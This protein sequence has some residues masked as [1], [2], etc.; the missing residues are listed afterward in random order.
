[1]TTAQDSLRPGAVLAG[2]YEVLRL[3]GIGARKQVHVAHD[4][5]LDRDVAVCA[6][7]G[8]PEEAVRLRR[9]AALLARLGDHPCIVA[10]HDLLEIG[11]V[12]VMICQY[13]PGGALNEAL[14]HRALEVPAALRIASDV[15]AAL[16][17]AHHHDV[18]HRDVKPANI[19]LDGQGRAV[20]GDF[21]IA[22]SGSVDVQ[23][24]D[25]LAGTA[26]YAAP[27][28][29]VGDR[30]DARSDLYSLGSVLFELLT[31]RPPFADPSLMGVV[32][33]VLQE[34]AVPPSS[35][36]PELPEG[37]D[38]L[39][40][41][42][43]AKDPDQRPSSADELL[44][45]LQA[46][47]SP[48]PQRVAA[49]GRRSG[50]VG[51]SSELATLR[52]AL[53]DA[54][55]G[56]GGLTLLLGEPGI[57]KTR[58]ALE[59]ARTAADE[60]WT[61]LTGRC[62]DNASAPAF[63]PWV[64]VLQAAVRELAEE[65]RTA[66]RH[67]SLLGTLVPELGSGAAAEELPDRETSRFLL[68]D[69]VAGLL[70]R[71]AARAPVLVLLDDVHWADAASCALT[72]FVGRELSTARVAV[73]AAARDVHE[74]EDPPG[75]ARV[76]ELAVTA[77]R[78]LVLR[79]LSPAETSS[80]LE[81]AL[82]LTPDAGL[83]GELHGR[84]DGNPF[85][86][87]ELVRLLQ[88]EHRI[89]QEG[90]LLPGEQH[91]P[92]SVREVLHR[93]LRHVP[94]ECA[95]LLRTMSV[96]GREVLVPVLCQVEGR[97][98]DD[99]V[100]LLDEAVAARLV[101]HVPASSGGFRFSHALVR[102]A[103]Y[104]ELPVARRAALHRRTMAA[105]LHVRAGGE[106]PA[107]EMA[108]HA[109]RAMV[110]GDVLPAVVWSVRAGRQAR[111]SSAHEDAVLHYSRAVELAST[112]ELAEDA[113][114]PPFGDLL[115]E[116]GQSQH[117]LGQAEQARQ[118]FM[119]AAGDAIVDDDAELLAR[120][121]L[122][123]GLGLG[124]FG[125]VEHADGVLL[126][127]LEEAAAALG[128]QD[129]PLRMRVLARLAT[130]LYFTPFRSRR[131]VLSRQ[132]LDMAARLRDPAGE[133]L[134]LY[135]V[136]LALLGPDG[137]DERRRTADR[138]VWLA[139]SLADHEMAF[140]G[141]HLRL[142]VALESGNLEQA[143]TEVSSCRDIAQTHRQP[144]HDWHAGVFEAMLPL[145]AGQFEEGLQL[146]HRALR[147]GRRGS[148]EMAQVMHAAQ[149]LVAH[150][151]RGRLDEV[152]EAA[153]AF[154]DRYPHAPAW[155]AA[156]A[157]CCTELD[158]L[159]EART[160]LEMLA[161]RDFVDLP[162][163]GNYLTTATF[164]AHVA[165][166]LG[167][168]ARARQLEVKLR[169]YA[170]RHV[171][172]AAGAVA[173]TCVRLAL[174][175]TRA[176]CGDLDGAVRDVAKAYRLHLEQPAPAYAVWSGEE[177]VRLLLSRGNPEDLAAART[178][179]AECVPVARALGMRRHLA[180]LE[181]LAVR[182]GTADELASQQGECGGTA[183]SILICDVARSSE[184][185]ERLGERAM[186]ALLNDHRRTV[187]DA[188]GGEGGV[189]LKILGDA[190][191]AAFSSADGA[192]RCAAR[193]Q[194]HYE[195]VDSSP[196]RVRIGVHTGPVLRQGDS[197]YGRTMIL[198]FRV[199]DRA[200]AGEVLVSSQAVSAARTDLVFERP[201]LLVLKGIAQPQPVHRLRW[202]DER[203]QD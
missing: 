84:T 149:V 106:V 185:T 77:G 144:S 145:A 78:T 179:L 2:R 120:A 153:S 198:A 141:H 18:V 125:F 21:G 64:Q 55:A 124:G 181:E 118:T 135:S 148:Q 5:W 72:S 89:T 46:L 92:T 25:L 134:A 161:A 155:R 35:L 147:S 53:D 60:G 186:H 23:P 101:S 58:T 192:L 20:L 7:Q 190:V 184:L 180:R 52:H 47:T 174:G 146:S 54:A 44:V 62:H 98:P 158:R 151:A 99:A 114:V 132:A 19:W 29:I 157:F 4:T 130:E 61:V 128:E 39:V 79:G 42:L 97:E 175:A 110:D 122:G 104:D 142:M 67:R 10:V 65:E 70:A 102:E 95:Q 115:L 9:E 81:A 48:Q 163:D 49:A 116:L 85:Y 45:R 196:V 164:L 82:K 34:P 31:G 150:W 74:A 171:V 69:A 136:T 28:Q 199:A 87:A 170:E 56:R 24:Y 112:H 111:L 36:R 73:V 75:A 100:R 12:P 169:P 139:T 195:Q 37:V 107:P 123:Y 17:R 165:A 197:M 202:R 16:V 3:I 90:R 11:S 126:S 71:L 131:L 59:L 152:V 183:V 201:E 176:A 168:V 133:L 80:F 43:L 160:Q 119:R 83:L 22:L 88:S 86:V 167:D 188:T 32:S 200:R 177:L 41:A 121:A 91:V 63:W 156:Y 6:V 105:L 173:F 57:G 127:L 140:R 68:F 26:G 103:L 159:D 194:Q 189:V 166:R 108:H 66:L 162:E 172:L 96:I 1:M 117:R 51:R 27:E 137:F 113:D 138:V 38:E 30:G 50:F 182:T 40:L 14:Q 191:L 178:T 193:L 109:L 76:A 143:R 94:P 129:S 15:T 13:L 8:A 154:A 33:K 187:E 203:R 93:R